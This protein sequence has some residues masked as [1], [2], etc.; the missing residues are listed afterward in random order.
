[1][2]NLPLPCKLDADNQIKVDRF[3]IK[4]IIKYEKA[5]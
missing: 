2:Y 4:I 1:M 3:T 5:K